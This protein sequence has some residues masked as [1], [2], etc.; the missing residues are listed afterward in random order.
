MV[1][2]V[3]HGWVSRHLLLHQNQVLKVIPLLRFEVR[4]DLVTVVVDLDLWLLVGELT[5]ANRVLILVLILLRPLH[6]VAV[7]PIR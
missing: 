1:Q 7:G 5:L 4:L 3:D 6:T 2:D